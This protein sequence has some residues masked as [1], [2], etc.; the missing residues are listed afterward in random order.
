MQK[1]NFVSRHRRYVWIFLFAILSTHMTGPALAEVTLEGWLIA[2]KT[3]PALQSIRKGT[4]PGDARVE[5]DRAYKLFAKNDIAAT[6]YLIAIKGAQPERRWVATDCGFHVVA[7]SGGVTPPQPEPQPQPQPQPQPTPGATQYVLAAS[8]QP[9]FCETKPS[10]PECASQT[11][12][13]FDA[14][15]LALHGLWPQPR[16]NVYCSVSSSDVA[17][18]K[19]GRWDA[20]PGINLEPATKQALDK[21]MP[22]TQSKLERHEWI[23]HGTCYGGTTEEYFGSAVRLMDAVNTSAV[24]ALFADNIGKELSANDIRDAFDQ[25][26]GAGAG[27]R[28]KVSCVND[29]NRRLI[30]EITIGLSGELE[31]GADFAALLFASPP[32]DAGCP[33]GIVDAVGLQ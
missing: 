14:T 2:T 25:S 10:K 26:F 13:R 9:G 24:R 27:E 4:N 32:T 8:W 11:A 16:S 31:E 6:H 17:A 23:K 33:K 30:G 20:L 7:A 22:G 21:V 1:R 5:P 12:D 29:G 3:C 19:D 15:N 28:V 18:D